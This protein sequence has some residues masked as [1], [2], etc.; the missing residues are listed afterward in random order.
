MKPYIIPHVLYKSTKNEVER[1]EKDVLLLS[2]NEYWKYLSSWF[3]IPE[4]DQTV[5]F[6]ADFR[7][8]N[9]MS[10]SKPHPLPNTQETLTTAGN[11]TYTT[12]VDLVMGY[13]RMKLSETA[14]NYVA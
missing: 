3:T 11:A 1:I 7:K 4:K 13:Y 12:V 10:I 5:Q 9:K 2:R 14:K 6:I 8:L